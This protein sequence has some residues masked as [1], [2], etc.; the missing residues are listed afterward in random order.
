MKPNL[1]KSM[2]VFW[3]CAAGKRLSMPPA[4][5]VCTHRLSMGSRWKDAE[6]EG[7]RG[8]GERLLIIE[9]VH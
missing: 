5:S 4:E 1:K 8:A 9:R 2:C 3:C 6:I 7:W